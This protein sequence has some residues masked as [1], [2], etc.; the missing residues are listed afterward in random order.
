MWGTA[1]AMLVA[2]RFG[3]GAASG[4]S[5]APANGSAIAESGQRI[6]PVIQIREGCGRGRHRNLGHCVP[7]CGFGWF[8]PYPEMIRLPS[9][10]P[11]TNPT[12]TCR[13]Q[14]ACRPSCANSS[15]PPR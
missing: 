1:V 3:L 14:P 8:Q 6:D 5:A 12:P 7:G 13:R 15:A 9:H 10:N 11:R 2:T 4:A